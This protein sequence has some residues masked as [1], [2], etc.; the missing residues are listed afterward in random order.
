ML[1]RKLF[2][3]LLFV[4]FVVLNS[5]NHAANNSKQ[6]NFSGAYA[7]YPLNLKW[8]EGYKK[9][10]A[11]IIFNIQPG[12]AGKGLTDALS[13]NADVGMF[14][15]EISDNELNKGIWYIALA[16][17]AVFPVI[18]SNNIYID[19][20]KAHG[21]TQDQ[22]KN[23]FV[24]SNTETWEDMLA[25]KNNTQ[26]KIDVYS[27][28]DASGAAESWAAFFNM[29]QDNL[30]GIAM[31]GDPGIANAV[32]KD[33]NGIGFNN[34]QYVFD[35][36]TGN[37]IQGIDILPLDVN[38][39]G[40]IDSIENFYNNL[41]SVET[42]VLDGNYPSPPVRDLYFVCKQ[43][44]TNQTILDYFKWVLTDGQQYIKDAG[45]IPL[46]ADVIQQQ[47]QKLQ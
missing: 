33:K 26:T 37:K 32:K 13:G 22:L 46:P 35:M 30:K 24:E 34:T 28:A 9:F 43:K 3:F 39:N 15:R 16:K 10:H 27:R 7:L 11:D 47:L 1:S 44:P 40:K 17:D 41:S 19:S 31:M 18:N 12:G 4:I 25:I 45:Y 6:I 42:A 36:Q 14:S 38:G 29:R 2:S 8:S 20:I 23:I 21:L 5:C